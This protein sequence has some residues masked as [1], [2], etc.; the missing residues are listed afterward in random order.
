MADGK[1][2]SWCRELLTDHEIKNIEKTVIEAEK[3]TSAE[4]VPMLVKQSTSLEWQWP[5]VTL[6]I[7][8]L[9]S[10]AELYSP[11]EHWMP[12]IGSAAI[13][14]TLLL[15]FELVL[16][17]CFA[18]LLLKNKAVRRAFI[19]KAMAEKAVWDR[20]VREFYLSRIQETQG[21][22]GVLIFISALE[23]RAVVLAD[24]AISD[25][26][27][28]DYW[29]HMIVDLIKAK[30]E[31]KL[32]AGLERLILRCAEALKKDFP[33]GSLDVDEL[34]NLLIVRD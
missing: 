19:P 5:L 16:A 20:A 23:K 26:L 6:L 17:G 31:R 33:R 10:A 3:Q 7:A 15:I 32:A 30:K 34:S 11:I 14:M 22:T 24:Q 25:K 21:K 1:M 27:P 8:Y 28:K 9:A 4:I 18:W 12:A 2:L 29:Q 13:T